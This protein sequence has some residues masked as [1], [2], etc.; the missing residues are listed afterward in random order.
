MLYFCVIGPLPEIYTPIGRSKS[1]TPF[2][3]FELVTLPKSTEKIHVMAIR[4]LGVIVME[5]ADGGVEQMGER[6]SR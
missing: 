6:G 2:L 5:G 1:L 4:P 3:K